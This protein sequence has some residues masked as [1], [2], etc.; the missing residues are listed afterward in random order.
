MGWNPTTKILTAPISLGDI[1][2]AVQKVSGDLGTLCTAE[3]INMWSRRKPVRSSSSGI[4]T[5]A[6]FSAVNCGVVQPSYSTLD[7]LMN[8]YHQHYK[9]GDFL[10]NG[11][12][13]NRPR[14]AANNPAE[15]YR[16]LD[17]NGYKHDA[18]SPFG[19]VSYPSV[20]RS[21]NNATVTLALNQSTSDGMVLSDLGGLADY[22]IGVYLRQQTGGATFQQ[23]FY[24]SQ[25]KIG[26]MTSA[27][28]SIPTTG[29]NTGDYRAY[30]FITATR[31]TSVVTNPNNLPSGFFPL[32]T[33]PR[34]DFGS[35]PISSETANI[36][37]L[38][39]VYIMGGKLYARLW[40]SSM[41]IGSATAVANLNFKMRPYGSS[42]DWGATVSGEVQIYDSGRTASVTPDASGNGTIWTIEAYAPTDSTRLANFNAMLN[43]TSD[44]FLIAQCKIASSTKNIVGTIAREQE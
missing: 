4:L 35:F 25:T 1:S 42:A 21:G 19:D 24:T 39:D 14:G 26:S 30:L 17:F 9:G 31:L 16:A 7:A 37:H 11:W 38:S 22:Y 3:G 8:K 43:A 15:W 33:I 32:A 41:T 20:V 23:A 27:S 6:E 34:I 44:P 40:A 2:A 29:L 12:G 10:N 18:V 28:I 13:Y 36:V 5:D